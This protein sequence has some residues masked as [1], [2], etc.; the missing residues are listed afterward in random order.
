MVRVSLRWKYPFQPPEALQ[1]RRQ[2]TG[3]QERPIA[4]PRSKAAVPKLE[5]HTVHR[6]T[7]TQP[8]SIRL[9]GSHRATPLNL[10]SH[11]KTLPLARRPAQLR[12]RPSGHL[13]ERET[14]RPPA[15]TPIIDPKTQEVQSPE[16]EV[17]A[18]VVGGLGHEQEEDGAPRDSD[19]SQSSQSR[20]SSGS[21]VIIIPHPPRAVKKGDR[22]RV[23]ILSLSFHPSSRV[24]LDQSVQRVYVE[25]RLLSVPME[26]T[27][28]PMSLRKP[29]AGEEIHYNFTR[30]IYVDSA[31][32]APLR[33]YLYTMLEGSDPNQGRLKFTVVSEPMDEGEEECVDVGHAYLDLQ[34]VLLT[35]NDVTERQIDIVG[36]HDEVE[37]G[38]L[39]VSVEAAQALRDIY[40][41]QRSLRETERET[42]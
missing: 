20:A 25:Y 7:Q 37:L 21:D 31:E 2:R 39:K 34:E 30:V 33:Q 1:S 32:A 16:Q 9:R 19:D 5:T 18:S 35:G 27:E 42:E 4:K 26:T 14:P 15:T 23:E 3:M 29:T 24:A 10:V 22:V 28:T 40:W 6:E 38:K 41:E 13:T 11:L 12:P 17:E 36:V 8:P